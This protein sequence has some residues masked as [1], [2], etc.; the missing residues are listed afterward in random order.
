M[1][2]TH[3]VARGGATVG[4]VALRRKCFIEYI[5]VYIRLQITNFIL[6][7]YLQ[8][9]NFFRMQFIGLIEIILISYYQTIYLQ[10]Y[11]NYTVFFLICFLV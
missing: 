11:V 3:H 4:D 9:M 2:E 1:A 5:N 6:S 10:L 8:L 7:M